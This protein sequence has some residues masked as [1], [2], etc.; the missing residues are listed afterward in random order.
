[1]PDNLI[2]DAPYRD[3]GFGARKVFEDPPHLQVM[4]IALK[5]GQRTP[6]HHANAN[7]RIIVLD[8]VVVAEVDGAESAAAAGGLLEAAI[9]AE[10]E[11][12]NDS[13]TDATFIVIKSPHPEGINPKS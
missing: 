12:R 6:R 11:I 3:G 10:M 8:G 4:Q 2:D 1:M 13:N 9:G 7:A 5:P